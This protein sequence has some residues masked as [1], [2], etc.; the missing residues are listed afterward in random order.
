MMT[1][2]TAFLAL[3]LVS[4]AACSDSAAVPHDAAPLDAGPADAACF[5]D[6]KTHNEI[7]NACT[8]AVKVYKDSRPPLMRPDG[9]LPAL[10]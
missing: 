9:S 8:S 7:I 1:T 2:R 10:P 6:P 3:V 4:G 5:T